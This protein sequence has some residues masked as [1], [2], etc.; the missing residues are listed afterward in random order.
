VIGTCL[1]EGWKANWL[2]QRTQILGDRHDSR[3][4]SW[5][6]K[7]SSQPALGSKAGGAQILGPFA[8]L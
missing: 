4:K 5:E 7:E 8:L 3:V 2:Y 1:A 6:V